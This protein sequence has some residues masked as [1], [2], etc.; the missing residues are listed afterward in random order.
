MLPPTQMAQNDAFDDAWR[1]HI[2]PRKCH[3]APESDHRK[4][5]GQAAAKRN[6]GSVGGGHINEIISKL[7]C[8]VAQHSRPLLVAAQG[9]VDQAVK[10]KR[11][12][13]VIVFWAAHAI[14]IPAIAQIVGVHRRKAV[15]DSRLIER[16]SG[17]FK[18]EL[19][20]N[21]K[22]VPVA[23]RH[24]GIGDLIQPRVQILHLALAEQICEAVLQQRQPEAIGRHLH[25]T[26]IVRRGFAPVA[27]TVR[28]GALLNRG[29]VFLAIG[30]A[31]ARCQQRKQAPQRARKPLHLRNIRRVVCTRITQ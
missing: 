8:A 14:G 7:A 25:Q 27:C 22:I 16:Q 4:A 1:E 15:I 21:G 5:V 10:V 3:R 31:V 17:A 13:D 9:G 24:L 30:R 12:R 2:Q 19:D 11:H 20:H 26:L 23:V 6:R 28:I 18:T 29:D